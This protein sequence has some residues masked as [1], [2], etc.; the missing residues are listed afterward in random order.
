MCIVGFCMAT[1]ELKHVHDIYIDS[2]E[3][4]CGLDHVARRIAARMLP[5]G[6][7]GTGVPFSA[8]A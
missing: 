1:E 8:G 4:I 3:N 2:L 5:S 6:S 7:V